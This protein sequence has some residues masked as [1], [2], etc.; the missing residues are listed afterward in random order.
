M[1][2]ATQLLMHVADGDAKAGQELFPLVYD[3]L[4]ALAAAYFREERPDHS[5][6]PTAL[7]HEAYLRLIDSAAAP[8]RSREHFHALAARVM[9]HVLVDHARARASAKRGG[10][11][12]RITL[13]GLA[14]SESAQT[15]FDF[16]AIDRALNELAELDARAAEVVEMRFFGSLTLDEIAVV[17]GVSLS[18]CERSWRFARAW[19][20]D[21]LTQGDA[22]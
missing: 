14:A 7:V 20:M 21:R 17:L 5:L 9:R 13:L 15:P 16:E 11:R 10:D 1:Q 6:Q 18:S 8:P 4:R 3:Q 19:L 12:A 22:G 2:R